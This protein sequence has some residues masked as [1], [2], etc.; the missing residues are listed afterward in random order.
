MYKKFEQN[1]YFNIVKK[2][3]NSLKPKLISAGLLMAIIFL[4]VQNV[5][6][7]VGIRQT[8]N[9]QGKLVNSSGLNVADSTYSVVFSL[10]TASSGGSNIW[11]ETQSVPTIDGLFRVEL[12]SSTSLSGVDFNQDELYLGIKVGADAE[13]TPRVRFTATPYAFQAKNVSWSGLQNPTAN[14]SLN[15]GAY[16]NSL[17]FSGTSASSDLFVLSSSANTT[18]TGRLMSLRTATDS[19]ISPFHVSAKGVEALLV[20]SSGN[21]G[22]GTTNPNFQLESVFSSANTNIVSSSMRLVHKST[23]NMTDGFGSGFVFGIDDNANSIQNMA[24]IAGVRDGADNTGKLV[25]DVA[26]TGTLDTKMTILSGG[27]VGIGTTSPGTNGAILEITSSKTS[28][29]TNPSQFRVNDGTTGGYF[30]VNEGATG[31]NVYV[32]TFV[33]RSAAINGLGFSLSGYIPSTNDVLVSTSAAVV[34]EGSK[35]TSGSIGVLTNSNILTVRNYDQS[36]LTIDVDGNVGIGTTNPGEK[37]DVVGN[38]R[39]TTL[40]SGGVVSYMFRQNSEG[41]DAAIRWNQIAGIS[42]LGFYLDDSTAGGVGTNEYLTILESGLVGIGTTNPQSKLNVLHT[43]SSNAVQY[44]GI[45]ELDFTSTANNLNESFGFGATIRFKGTS[46]NDSTDNKGLSAFS[47]NA[48]NSNTGTVDYMQGMYGDTRNLSTGTVTNFSGIRLPGGVNSGG[49]TI[50]NFYGLLVEAQSVGTNRYALSLNNAAATNVYNVYAGGTAQ[51]YFAGNVGIGMANPTSVL[52]TVASGARTANYIGNTLTNTSTSSTPSITKTG[53][54]IE[55]TGTWSGASAVNRGLYVNAT[56]GTTNYS[57]IFDGGNVGIGTTNPA[58][59]L[60]VVGAITASG[61]ISG[62]GSGLT[63]LNAS[64]ISSG[65]IPAASVLNISGN[66]AT[67]TSLAT[68]RT[69]W[70]Q[71]FNGTAIITGALTGVTSI[72]ASG[73]ISGT[74]SGLTNLNASNISSGT[75]PAASVFDISGNAAT[76]TNGVYTTGNQTIGGTKTFSSVISGTASNANS[77]ATA[78]TIWGQSFN[79]TAIIT[80]ALTGV[81]SITASGNVGIGTVTANNRLV[82]GADIGASGVPNNTI[83]LGNSAGN[84]IIQVGQDSSNKGFLQ[85][86]YNATVANAFYVVGSGNGQPVVIQNNN[87]LANYRVGIGTSAPERKLHVF[88][89]ADAPPVRFQDSNGYCEINP[90]VTTW[91]CVSDASLKYDVSSMSGVSN[92]QKLNQLRPVSFKWIS[93]TDNTKKY[94][95]IAQEMEQIFPEFVQTDEKG[96]KSVSYGSLTPILISAI[97]EQQL[98]IEQNTTALQTLDPEVINMQARIVSLEAEN[99]LTEDATSI[100]DNLFSLIT[101][102][103]ERITSLEDSVSELLSRVDSLV[104]PQVTASDSAR[105]EDLSQRLSFVEA[106]FMGEMSQGLNSTISAQLASSIT[107]NEIIFEKNIVSENN[108]TV[109][110]ETN[111]NNVGVTGVISNN[112]LLINGFDESLATPGASISTVTGALNIQKNSLNE[113]KFMGESFK[114]DTDGNFIIHKGNLEVA[115]GSVKGNDGVRGINVAVEEGK[116]ELKVVFKEANDTANYAVGIS[117]SWFTSFMVTGKDKFGFTVKF[118]SPA[119]VGGKIDWIVIE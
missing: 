34:I 36:L 58:V 93:Q 30:A 39:A 26:T 94:G 103:I 42:R 7:A 112:L 80:G 23:G 102:S 81:T 100:T 45:S 56:G 84:S 74:G 97:Q 48:F 89:N 32:P 113:I 13:M 85:W 61:I 6:S 38:I 3:I 47:F 37:L 104:A 17:I 28:A 69:I 109:L 12:G 52:H 4:A 72:T 79:G 10:Y 5:Y 101:S 108:L 55:S 51:N 20:A 33:G 99:A 116:G 95:L 25:F 68:T 35:D 59:A 57:A 64:N 2:A 115:M 16:T 43:I 15:M 9:F 22:I 31:A 82:V 44:A 66:A 106:M 119:P 87:A 60:Q 46:G 67:A 96:L 107:E 76:V 75:I 91:A 24:R 1:K 27:N 65:T 105:I 54:S 14:T 50:T 86:V 92:L 117:P 111:L 29:V 118:S 19:E 88:V 8:I 49:G 21:V 110:A 71:S 40:D 18:G 90:T 98:Q 41:M 114:M 77:L 63:N 53:L 78:R 83:S 62:T 70:G 11:Q 73:I